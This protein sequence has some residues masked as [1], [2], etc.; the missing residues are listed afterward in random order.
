MKTFWARLAG[1]AFA[2]A[3]TVTAAAAADYRVVS[4]GD[5]LSDVGNTFEFTSG[6]KPAS[7]PYY[8]GRFSNGPV[9]TEILAGGAMNKFSS[10]INNAK[11][12]NFAFGG[13]YAGTGGQVPTIPTQIGAYLQKGGKFAAKDVVTL[14]GGANDIFVL[15]P[16]ST[17]TN[18]KKV[19][20]AAADAMA[21]NLASVLKAGAKVV[22]I[23]NLPALDK[24]PQAKLASGLGTVYALATKTYN[25]RLAAKVTAA[26]TANPTAKIVV[27]DLNTL[28][29]SVIASP[30]TFGFTNVTDACV[31]VPACVSASTA[32][33]NEY[34][35]FDDVHP[36]THAHEITAFMARWALT[37]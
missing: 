11:D 23:S 36:T 9:W 21:A 2:V 31:R 15:T 5:S 26:R 4:F 28:F 13:A 8:Q 19:A 16:A 3:A 12:T 6:S 10:A 33:Q 37:H 32:T 27:L 29:S 7:P 20:T 24:T 1:A 17:A 22:V 35:F 14:L 25:T 30:A 18:T 34:M